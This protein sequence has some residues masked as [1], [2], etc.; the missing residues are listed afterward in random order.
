MCCWKNL[1]LPLESECR[2]MVKK[3]EEKGLRSWSAM[4]C[5]MPRSL[6]N[7]KSS[8]DSGTLGDLVNFELTEH[9][10][11]WHFAH[12]YVRGIFRNE[13][14]S[15]PG[16]WPNPATIWISLP[17]SPEERRCPLWQRGIFCTL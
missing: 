5:A 10:A 16:S 4:C 6:K 15:A 11:Y 7:L 9:V 8:T 12:A 14:S 17:T 13:A 3:A 1:W 2:E